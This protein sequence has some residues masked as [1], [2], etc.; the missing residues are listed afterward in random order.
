MSHDLWPKNTL[1]I[2]MWLCSR[3]NIFPWSKF[4][5]E[6]NHKQRK[7]RTYSNFWNKKETKRR[8]GRV[9]NYLSRQEKTLHFAQFI[10]IEQIKPARI[11]NQ[12]RKG[13]R[14]AAAKQREMRGVNNKL[15]E[16]D[17]KL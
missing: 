15:A 4:L 7:E 5:H 3:V 13:K 14:I 6:I 2:T 16:H 1:R 9:R 12:R 10:D 8:N 11:R 17:V